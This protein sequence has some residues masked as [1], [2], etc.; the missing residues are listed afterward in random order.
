MKFNFKKS[1]TLT[2]CVLMALSIS[3]CGKNKEDKKEITTEAITEATTA[4]ETKNEKSNEIA[5]SK[6]LS[7]EE[8]MTEVNNLEG[9]GNNILAQVLKLKQNLDN[10]KFTQAEAIAEVE[11][12]KEI[13]KGYAEFAEISNV[14]E[15][16]EEIH[17]QLAKNSKTFYTSTNKLLDI[18]SQAIQGKAASEEE[19]KEIQATYI[20]DL[21]N[22]LNTINQ[23]KELA[24]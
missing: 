10:K 22:L 12:I 17:S 19:L 21:S 5:S 2:A 7:K 9:I 3:A 6:T 8:Y 18:L 13:S 20:G 23:A 24:K 1:I 15:E 14:P 16:F 11:K 4:L